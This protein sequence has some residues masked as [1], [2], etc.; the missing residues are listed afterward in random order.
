MSEESNG[1]DWRTGQKNHGDT[2]GQSSNGTGAS[3]TRT[4]KD[5]VTGAIIADAGIRAGEIVAWRCW[6]VSDHA[7]LFSFYREH[8]WIPGQL[9]TGDV[10]GE[11]GVYAFKDPIYAR[12]YAVRERREAVYYAWLT[13]PR[14]V[15][16]SVWLWGEII[17]HEYG[18]RASFAKVRS[19]EE[20]W[21]LGNCLDGLRKR[22][23]V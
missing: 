7:N 5:A 2:L 19:L 3:T 17:E 18:Y 23:G 10:R 16:G 8:E 12:N 6:R 9:M 20:V 22:Y 14:V 4:T 15:F 1:R 21:G 13:P 11:Y